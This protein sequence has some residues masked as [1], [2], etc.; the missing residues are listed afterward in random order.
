ML[1]LRFRSSFY[2]LDQV[3]CQIATVNITSQSVVCLFAFLM[4]CLEEHFDNAQFVNFFYNFVSPKVIAFPK[5][6]KISL[7]KFFLEFL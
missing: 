4:V 1:S 6:T 3:P 7:L 2:V 5:V